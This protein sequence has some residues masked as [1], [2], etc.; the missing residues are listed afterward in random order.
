MLASANFSRVVFRSSVDQ[1]VAENLGFACTSAADPVFSLYPEVLRREGN[2]SGAK[3][4]LICNEE[5]NARW[6]NPS[7]SR[8]ALFSYATYFS[9][10]LAKGFSALERD[11]WTA[12]PVMSAQTPNDE[13][14]VLDI[15]SRFEQPLINPDIVRFGCLD[16]VRAA[17]S[18]ARFCISMRLHGIILALLHEVPVLA[19]SVGRKIDALMLE[20]GLD[21]WLI[22]SDSLSWERLQ[23]KQERLVRTSWDEFGSRINFKMLRD[24]VFEEADICSE[25][26]KGSMHGRGAVLRFNRSSIAVGR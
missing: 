23:E 24:S 8:L 15:T 3:A 20:I 22:P 10:V 4:L 2:S 17:F 12:W 1:K 9:E 13:N 7:P 5:M 6:K 11:F 21:E 14:M 16:D 25:I 19:V 18:S 26:I